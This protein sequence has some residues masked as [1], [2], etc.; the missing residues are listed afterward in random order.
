MDQPTVIV[1]KITKAHGLTGEVTVLSL[2]DN[3][4]RF[5]EGN[6]VLLQDGRSLRIQEVRAN[7]ARLLV[8]F[9]G[10]A[11]RT[12][13]EALGGA[14]LVVPESDLPD[15]P[16]GTYWPHE[17]EG[18]EVVTRAGRSFGSITEVVANPANDIWI[19]T[20]PEGEET[21][22]PAIGQVIAEV[23]IGGRRVVVHEVPGITAPEE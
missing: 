14:L 23:D 19:A 7:G 21:L 17:L 15:L 18:C 12:S 1:G 22:V 9:A 8:T 3:P 16:E 10:I 20:G 13:A 6:V 4:D 11:D 5:V 2:T